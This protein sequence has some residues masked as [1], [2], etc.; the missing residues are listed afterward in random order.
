M[1]PRANGDLKQQIVETIP[2]DPLCARP[3]TRVDLAAPLL[4]LFPLVGIGDCLPTG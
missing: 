2:Y 3:V 4:L 1:L